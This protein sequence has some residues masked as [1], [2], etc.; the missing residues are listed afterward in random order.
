MQRF[1]I[2]NWMQ[3]HNVVMMLSNAYGRAGI[4]VAQLKVSPM[5]FYVRDMSELKRTE[6][7]DDVRVALRGGNV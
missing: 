3:L 7:D 1:E 6:S 5:A 4:D 2:N